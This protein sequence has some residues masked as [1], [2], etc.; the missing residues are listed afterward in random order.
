M[1]ADNSLAVSH[2]RDGHDRRGID[3]L[4]TI[5]PVEREHALIQLQNGWNGWPLT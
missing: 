3:L 4:L 2:H 1:S 5:A